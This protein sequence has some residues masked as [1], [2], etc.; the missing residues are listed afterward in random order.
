MGGIWQAGW[1]AFMA[2]LWTAVTY[3]KAPIFAG[4]PFVKLLILNIIW[5]ACLC[6]FAATDRRHGVPPLITYEIAVLEP[7][8]LCIV[9]AGVAT[10]RRLTRSRRVVQHLD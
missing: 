5:T 6:L 9:L 2:S 3:F 10:V 1:V 8:V 4:R 7:I